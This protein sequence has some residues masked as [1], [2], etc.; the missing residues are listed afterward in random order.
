MEDKLDCD[1]FFGTSDEGKIKK[2][3]Y[4]LFGKKIKELRTK[5][6]FIFNRIAGSFYLI[7]KPYKKY[8][9]TGDILCVSN[10][11]IL[12]LARLLNKEVY[13][14]T[15]GWYGNENQSKEIIKKRFFGLS[16]GLFLYGDYAKNLM[17]KAGFRSKKLHVVYNSLNYTQQLRIRNKL[18]KTSIYINYFKNDYPVL[19]FTGRL[20]QVKSLDIL[21][22]AVKIL[23]EQQVFF[24]V[25]LIGDGPERKNLVEFVKKM[26]M[27]EYVLFYGDCY[28]EN[29]IGN[30]FYNASICIS[31]GNVGLTS[32]HSMMF[33]CPV[34]THDKFCNQMPEFEIIQ[35]GITGDFFEYGS[36]TDLASTIHEWIKRHPVKTKELISECFKKVDEKYNPHFQ[37]KVIKS[38]IL[39]K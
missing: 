33:G 3:E 38:V 18:K 11:L 25:F 35:R 37:I 26:D 7:F 15:H 9:L 12:I 8:V 20:T 21:L 31:P 6:F 28:D 16:T 5:R 39:S 23:H 10:W 2:I 36:V 30:L 32:I 29:I 1:F 24:N 27:E 13:L 19:I 17:I 14:W 4:S 34:I 22:G